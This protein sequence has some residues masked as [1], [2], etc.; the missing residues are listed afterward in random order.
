[1]LSIRHIRAYC[2][3]AVLCGCVLPEHGGGAISVGGATSNGVNRPGTG[4][5][6]PGVNSWTSGG[7]SASGGMTVSGGTGS[8]LTT[9]GGVSFGGT[10]DAEHAMR[11]DRHLPTVGAHDNLLLS[12]IEWSS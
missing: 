6:S 3:A 4:G 11:A 1:M 2:T 9:T 7:H 12:I 8:N 5:S 10:P